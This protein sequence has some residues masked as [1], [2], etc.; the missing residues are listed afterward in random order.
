M[1][2]SCY[3]QVI[4]N[5]FTKYH[6]IEPYYYIENDTLY[7]MGK[8]I[9]FREQQLDIKIALSD[10]ESIQSEYFNLANTILLVLGI[11]VISFTVAGA[12]ATAN[13][14]YDIKFK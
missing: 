1:K 10:I 4:K 3:Y 7:G 12:I 11:S 5:D 6:F 9:S 14:D 8:L 13:A 2:L